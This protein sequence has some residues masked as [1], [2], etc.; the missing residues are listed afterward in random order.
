MVNY[1]HSCPNMHDQVTHF[2]KDYTD[3]NLHVSLVRTQSETQVITCCHLILESTTYSQ[4]TRT[5]IKNCLVFCYNKST[6]PSLEWI[7]VPGSITKS[8]N[9]KFV[10]QIFNKH[11]TLR[12]RWAWNCFFG[13]IN[14]SSLVFERWN[15]YSNIRILYL[16]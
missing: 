9:I 11:V 13:S 5:C 12:C 4:L 3:H 6:Q 7:V 10:N 14:H 15:C 2:L 16:F 1:L 8:N